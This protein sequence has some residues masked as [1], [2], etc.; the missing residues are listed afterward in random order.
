MVVAT[1]QKCTECLKAE[2][3]SQQF[4][5]WIRPL[6]VELQSDMLRIFAPNRFIQ[7]WV[8]GKF[9]NRIHQIIEEMSEDSLQISL[10]VVSAHRPAESSVATQAPS[11]VIES[12]GPAAAKSISIITDQLSARPGPELNPGNPRRAV[13]YM[14]GG[15]LRH[16][17]RAQSKK[18]LRQFY[19]GQVKP[20]GKSGGYA[21]GRKSWL[22]L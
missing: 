7:D 18:Q 5:T 16:R 6:T 14:I 8:K 3:P 17:G 15:K 21:G 12:A 19:R 22:R 4:N 9:L 20:A 10:E 13:E 1:W 11:N 2:L